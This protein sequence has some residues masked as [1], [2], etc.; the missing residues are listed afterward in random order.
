MNFERQQAIHYLRAPA[1]GLWRWAEDGEVLVWRDGS[2]LAFRQEIQEI[3]EW[4]SPNG[5]PPFGSLVILLAACRG[6][7]P[8]VEDIVTESKAAL[9]MD[10]GKDAA[11]LL[12]ARQQLKIQL[13]HALGQLRRINQL[14]A[15]LN[16]GIRAR[17]LLAEAV[18]ETAKAERHMKA[19]DILLGLKSGL[20]NAA[21]NSSDSAE[22]TG[23]L[24]RQI[25]IVAEGLRPHTHESLALRLRTGLDALPEKSGL[26]QSIS[27]R[28]QRLIDELSRDH[29]IGAVA[30]AARELMAAAR[31]PRR[32]GE[33]DQL[34]LGGVSDIT[35][36][37]PLDRLLLSE[38][39]HDDLTLSVRV[40]LNEAL[41]LRREPPMRE[42]P[43]MLV[44]LFDSGLRLWGI[45][46]VLSASV[47][48]A[49]IACDK[50]HLQVQAWRAKGKQLV[51]VELL[52][53]NGL[54]QHLSVLEVEVDPGEALPALGEA[55]AADVR[56]QSVLITHRD[57]LAD[58]GF[59]Q[60]LSSM[61]TPPNFVATVDQEGRFELHA[62]PL[63]RRSPLCEAELDLDRILKED[64]AV[65]IRRRDIHPSLPAI[66]GMPTFPFLLPVAG[67][68]SRWLK[69]ENG[70]TYA[71][72]NDRSLFRFKDASRGA[73]LLTSELPPGPTF[74]MDC[75]D[76]TVHLVKSGASQRPARLVS[77]LP[78]S[79]VP[80]VTDLSS[81]SELLAVHR[82]GGV[83]LVLRKED[84]RAFALSDGRMVGRKVNPY[85]WVHGRYL[86][87]DR[88]FYFAS[89]DGSEICFDPVSLTNGFTPSVIA[90]IF[91]RP[92]ESGPWYI[93][94]GGMLISGS[95]GQ[96]DKLPMPP[97]QQYGIDSASVSRDGKRILWTISAAKWG[98]I[99]D[100]ESGKVTGFMPEF[101]KLAQLDTLPRLPVWNL[102]RTLESVATL[103]DGLAF[104]GAKGRWRQIFLNAK[105][106]ISIKE[107]P[108]RDSR[109][110]E[111]KK[112]AVP[113]IVAHANCSL[114]V[115]ELDN[116]V[117]VF[118]D[119]RGL[120]HLKG[121]DA[122]QYEITLVL[123]EREVAG[124]T[125]DGCVC[126]PSFFF[127]VDVHSEPIRVFEKCLKVL[128]A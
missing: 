15:E 41:Y 124:W 76:D 26:D 117:K 13:G 19:L 28:A 87:G 105:G 31:L 98:R 14:P 55:I 60:L 82:Y 52:T 77:F 112:F 38:L 106:E 69:A 65:S 36:R 70:F 17:C 66:L 128:N 16:S 104:R 61:P 39:A 125:S 71:V 88:A 47:G 91:D 90:L 123:S 113:T 44:M 10:M 102:F 108:E 101:R 80:R 50:Q 110:G 92:G 57:V 9:P 42:P 43:G 89:W 64:N 127:P 37:G 1:N 11:V 79:P 72:I 20:E 23:N 94:K 34:A 96:Q 83:I 93:H 24:I 119:S 54:M 18:F 84:V 111:E 21:L 35:N 68:V 81:G 118:W 75:A 30:R 59:R 7:I 74:W 22:V 3:I 121:K 56:S 27:E 6:K 95:T 4:L 122:Q 120:L 45:P 115:T 58:T 99:K 116:G 63:S 67:K 33:P 97:L 107:L 40:A 32:L 114:C 2:T 85:C 86:Q 109:L 62:L 25:H 29:E 100:L 48:L 73:E 103:P 8:A 12:A 78:S 51:P 49:L 53:R 46:R 126:G 5:L